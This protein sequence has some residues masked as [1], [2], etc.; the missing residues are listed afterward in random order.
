MSVRIQCA[1]RAATTF[2]S[3]DGS[4]RRPIARR[5]E[6]RAANPYPQR[7]KKIE[8]EEELYRL[9]V[10]DYRILYQVKG[11]DPHR[12]HRWHRT[13]A[14]RVSANRRLV[15]AKAFTSAAARMRRLPVDKLPV[16]Q[17]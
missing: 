9:R 11:K 12:P 5:I 7:I 3:R 14:R 13:P 2:K 15:M 10:G 17:T 6:A 1:P 8:D 16:F 4:I